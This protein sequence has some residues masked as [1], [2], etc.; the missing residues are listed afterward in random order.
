MSEAH[1][2]CPACETRIRFP[3]G[4]PD[5]EWIEC[6]RCGEEIPVSRPSRSRRPS[7]GQGVL[8]EETADLD[9]DESPPPQPP[10][11]TGSAHRPAR[12]RLHRV[13][14]GTR[15]SEFRRRFRRVV[16]WDHRRGRGRVGIDS[17]RDLL[18]ELRQRRSRPRRQSRSSRRRR[19]S[20]PGDR[21]RDNASNAGQQF[22]ANFLAQSSESPRRCGR[23][24]H[25]DLGAGA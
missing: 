22:V 11:A 19:E 15:F 17:G 18:R 23:Q 7:P 25:P 13:R 24:S 1:M 21:Q 8:R 5:R 12:G 9:D 16:G 3:S 20:K 14:R 2:F 4:L 10:R 6:P